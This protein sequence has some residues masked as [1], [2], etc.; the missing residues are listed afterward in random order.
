[1]DI[2]AQLEGSAAA[3][4]VT[5][6]SSDDVKTADTTPVNGGKGGMIVGGKGGKGGMIVGGKGGKG[7]MVFKP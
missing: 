4:A 1:M 2:V 7:G 6:A 3:A 5:E